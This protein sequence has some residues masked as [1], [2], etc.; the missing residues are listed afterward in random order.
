MASLSHVRYSMST[1][2]HRKHKY[3]QSMVQRQEW[4]VKIL[5]CGRIARAAVGKVSMAGQLA[6]NDAGMQ[7]FANTVSSCIPGRNTPSMF[8]SFKTTEQ[9]DRGGPPHTKEIPNKYSNNMCRLQTTLACYKD[10]F[11]N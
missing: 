1:M 7:A 9:Y 10:D 5:W 6:A 3:G 2:Q 4:H 8:T 11:R